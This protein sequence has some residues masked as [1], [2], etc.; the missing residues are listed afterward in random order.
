M[1]KGRLRKTAGKEGG[2]DPPALTEVRGSEEGG[3][4]GNGGKPHLWSPLL[5]DLAIRMSD[6]SK[7]G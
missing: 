4:E 1:V 2:G 5:P 6:P 3:P 7:N